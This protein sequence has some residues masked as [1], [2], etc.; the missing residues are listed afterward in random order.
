MNAMPE[1]MMPL[2]RQDCSPYDILIDLIPWY[3]SSEL[4]GIESSLTI[5]GRN[6][7]NISTSTLESLWSVRLLDS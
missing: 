1:W 2:P 5:P 7:D 4:K 3:V 6:Y